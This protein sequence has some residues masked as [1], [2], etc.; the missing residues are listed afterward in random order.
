MRYAAV[1]FDV[2]GTLVDSAADICGAIQ[3]ILKGTSR[4]DVPFDYLRSFIGR[5]LQDLFE[6]L[7]P[8]IDQAGVDALVQRYRETYWAREHAQTRP[9][10]GVLEVLP[11]LPGRKSTATTKGTPTTR[12]VL[13]KFGLLPHFDHVQGT[14]GFPSKP[15]PDVILK[16]LEGLG[17]RPEDCLFV[18]DSAPDMEAGRAAGVHVCAVHYGYGR[19]EDLARYAPE[20]AITSFAELSAILRG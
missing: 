6:E 16:A 14:D 8:G 12:I 10:P 11:S 13:E 19:P 20:H 1:L 17:A 9:Y 7:F 3:T 18:G 5:H 15:K 2:D 4:P